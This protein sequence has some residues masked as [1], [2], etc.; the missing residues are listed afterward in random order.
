MI[1]CNSDWHLIL[2][3][4][5]VWAP[6]KRKT[7]MENNAILKKLA[8]ALNLRHEALLQI[9]RLSEPT[10][11]LSQVKAYMVNPSH[12]NFLEL[13]DERLA[14]FLDNLITYSRGENNSDQLPMIY[15]HYII[16]LAE[17]GRINILEELIEVASEAFALAIEDDSD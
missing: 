6:K 1:K 17:S 3:N 5:I 11:N 4:V 13:P 16:S 15:R 10:M 2:L 12:K 9:F 7:K 8:I 14:S